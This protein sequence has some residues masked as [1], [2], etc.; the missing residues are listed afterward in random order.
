MV[1]PAIGAEE[2]VDLLA[3]RPCGLAFRTL[4]TRDAGIFLDLIGA[5]EDRRISG[6]D[7]QA[8]DA[9][10]VDWSF[11]LQKTTQREFAVVGLT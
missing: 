11:L 7:E 3:A 8:A 1:H 6:G 4:P 10:A 5:I 9:K 2:P